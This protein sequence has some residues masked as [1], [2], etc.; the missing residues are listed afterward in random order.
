VE[1]REALVDA[2][3]GEAAR[4]LVEAHIDPQR[5]LEKRLLGLHSGKTPRFHEQLLVDVQTGEHDSSPGST[6]YI[7]SGHHY[8]QRRALGLRRLVFSTGEGVAG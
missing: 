4:L 2:E 7:Q 5:L 1:Q 8:I 3:G 6:I